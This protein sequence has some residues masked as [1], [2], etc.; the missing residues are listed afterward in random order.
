MGKVVDIVAHYV[1]SD[2][3]EETVM[4]KATSRRMDRKRQRRA[5]NRNPEFFNTLGRKIFYRARWGC[6]FNPSD[7]KSN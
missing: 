6:G 5:L 7:L 4:S 2:C 1:Y 3:I